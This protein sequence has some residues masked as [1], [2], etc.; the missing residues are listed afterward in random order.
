M[1]SG[2]GPLIDS[3]GTLVTNDENMAS[4]LNNYFSSVFTS[5]AE[6]DHFSTNEINTI[7]EIGNS[8]AA[9]PEHTIHNFEIT[10]EEV[11]KALNNMK[12]N[13][14]SGPDNIHPTLLKETKSEIVDT[15]TSLFNISLCQ[16]LVLADWKTANV[17][18]IFKKGDRSIPGNY[19][20]ISLTSVVGKMLESIIR[21]KIVSY[22]EQHTL[23]RDS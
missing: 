4:V 8:T 15:L 2:I 13:K 19:R 1:R 9:I 5:T 17:T 14:S 12:T 6:A 11:L 21:D 20:P 18:P 22:L 3:T 23:I 7:D 16:G 10:P